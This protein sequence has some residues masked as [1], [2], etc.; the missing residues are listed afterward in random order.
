MSVLIAN[1][2]LRTI[3]KVDCKELQVK[4]VIYIMEILCTSLF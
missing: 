3:G 1:Q 4:W 2:R